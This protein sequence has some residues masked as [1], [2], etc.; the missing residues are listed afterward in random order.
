MLNIDVRLTV[1]EAIALMRAVAAK[2]WAERDPEKRDELELIRLKLYDKVYDGYPD[3]IVIDR[4][5][6]ADLRK[7]ESRL[8]LV[9]D[10][11]QFASALRVCA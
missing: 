9:A 10:G 1:D 6:H 5:G 2:Q 8:S 4:G 7:R 3:P 11:Q